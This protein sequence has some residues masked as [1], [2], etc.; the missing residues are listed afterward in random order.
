MLRVIAKYAKRKNIMTNELG[1]MIAI[2]YIIL[3]VLQLVTFEKMAGL[4]AVALPL[5]MAEQAKIVAS[6]LVVSEVFALPFLL[7]MQ[8][9]LAMRVLSAVLAYM[10]A[11]YIMLVGIMSAP[12]FTGYVNSGLGGG[13]AYVPNGPWLFWFGLG[14]ICLLVWYTVRSIQDEQRPARGA[15][16]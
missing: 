13:Y 11:M 12:S 4:I 15:K 8:L 5:G 2:L 3:A 1:A 14:V 9:S 16:S 7:G 6:V 10:V